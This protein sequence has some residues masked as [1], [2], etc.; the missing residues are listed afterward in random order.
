MAVVASYSAPE[1]MAVV[2][3]EQ[4]EAW[5]QLEVV[6]IMAEVEVEQPMH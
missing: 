3:K 4:E 1:I 6:E 2:D 5:K